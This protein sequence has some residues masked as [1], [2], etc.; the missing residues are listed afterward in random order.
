MK[1]HLTAHTP[2]SSLTNLA[3]RPSTNCNPPEHPS[4]PHVRSLNITMVPQLQVSINL[5]FAFCSTTRPVGHDLM[6]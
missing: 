2:L 6:V 5:K 3:A 1:P 4:A